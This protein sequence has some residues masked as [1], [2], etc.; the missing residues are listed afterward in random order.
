MLKTYYNFLLILCIFCLLLSACTTNS[1]FVEQTA[2]IETYEFKTI[3]NKEHKNIVLVGGCFDVLHFG[4]IEFLK[5]AKAAGDYLV[6][7]L[8]PDERILKYKQRNPT[9]T[10]QERAEILSAIRFVDKIILLPVLNGFED[11]NYL[12]EHVHP[13]VI[14]ITGGDS[15]FENKQKQAKSVG[16]TVEIVV[17]RLGNFSSS[18]IINGRSK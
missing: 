11:Y 5:K 16:A 12:V 8:E 6:I 15:Q 2:L 3:Q 14:A 9:H 7:A 17:Q 10:Q 13:R 1:T 4:H 18:A